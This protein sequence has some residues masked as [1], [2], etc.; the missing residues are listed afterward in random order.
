MLL[1]DSKNRR[2]GI[3]NAKDTGLSDKGPDSQ[4][5]RDSSQSRL[6]KLTQNESRFRSR[7]HNGTYTII[8]PGSQDI[9]CRFD[10]NTEMTE[11]SA[12]EICKFLPDFSPVES[13][14]HCLT[15]YGMFSC[16]PCFSDKSTGLCII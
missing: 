15:P 13:C 9:I 1:E 16:K 3:A 6:G 14:I 7:K 11:V 12:K 10:F 8:C 4:S 2:H 5:H